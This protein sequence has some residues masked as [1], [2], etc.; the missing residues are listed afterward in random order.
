M[1]RFRKGLSVCLS[2]LLERRQEALEFSEALE[3]ETGAWELHVCR[4]LGFPWVTSGALWGT[5][6]GLLGCTLHSL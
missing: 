3:L 4:P 5:G 1:C 2:F 6:L